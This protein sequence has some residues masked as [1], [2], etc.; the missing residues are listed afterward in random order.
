MSTN[1]GNEKSRFALVTGASGGIGY[2][3]ARLLAEDRHNLIVVARSAKQLEDLAQDMR[4]QHGIEVH[5]LAMDLAVPTAANE[6]VTRLKDQHLRV[7]ILVNN[8]GYGMYGSFV[9]HD[10]E[11]LVDMLNLNVMTL[12]QL[13]HLLLPAMVQQG[14]GRILNV[15]STGGFQPVP[16]MAAYAASKAF[17]LNFS[18]ALAQELQG[19]GVTITALCPGPT[20]TGFV[21]RANMH[22]SRMAAGALFMSATKVA[23][24]GYKAMVQGKPVVVTG[25][26]N[27]LQT[28]IIR[29]VPRKLVA[30]SAKCILN[31]STK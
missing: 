15:A 8:A 30:R 23:E 20:T 29:F 2:E 22:T 1:G 27:K 31:S 6:L 13:T 25:W 10:L 7:D 28:C 17:V 26:S 21:Q 16:L 18:E 19:T 11:Q 5:V 4:I 14:F 3:I 9:E 12:M 24:L